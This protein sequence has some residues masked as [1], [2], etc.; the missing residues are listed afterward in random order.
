M[1]AALR[2]A[3][4]ASAR[5]FS[6]SRAAQRDIAKMTLVGRLGAMEAKEGKNGRQYLKYAIATTDPRRPPREGEAPEEPTTSWHTIFA[7]GDAVERLQNVQVG[8][9]LRILA[10]FQ[11]RNQRDEETG[12][13]STQ[14]LAT[15]DRMSVIS[16]PRP[17]E[18]TQQ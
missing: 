1:F 12:N 16:K 11:V 2:P 3:A 4:R 13:Y 18:E 8:Q 10:S 7:N 15:H 17:R 6:T 14:L 9:V 5:A